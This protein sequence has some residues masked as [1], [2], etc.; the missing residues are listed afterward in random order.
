MAY[1]QTSVLLK[2][3][4]NISVAALALLLVLSA[5]SKKIITGNDTS[6]AITKD[7]S[8]H[9]TFIEWDTLTRQKIAPQ[10]NRNIGYCGY[11]R[12][13]QLQNGNLFCIYEVAGGNIECTQS[14]D[15]GKTWTTPVIIAT[16]TNGINMAVPEI[17]A[18]KDQ[19]LLASYN[20]RPATFDSSKHYGISIKKSYD[21]G[22]TWRDERL[23]YQAGAAFGDGCWEPSQ[24]QLPSGEIQLFFSNEGIYTNTNEQNISLLRAD[25]TGL[26]W[27]TE[28]QIVSFR[29]GKRD[30]MPVPILLKNKKAVI[31]SIEDNGNGQFAP[32]II[33]NTL[34]DDWATI[35]DANSAHRK[36]A[37]ATPLAS[38][39]YAGAPYLRQLNTGETILSYQSTEGRSDKWD[40]SCMNVVIGDENGNNFTNKTIPFTIPVDKIGLWNSL[41][42]LADDTVI[43]LTSTNAYSASNKVEVWMIKGHIVKR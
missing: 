19:T 29:A 33:S 40:L 43:A 16:S 14:A 9:G 18:L 2:L 27:T 15:L 39:I 37:L 7:T 5:C 30:G 24:I 26:N 38:S 8:L 32:S 13:I 41:C 4:K 20:L 36:A 23:L 12:M 42:I 3:L 21:G 10:L 34:T 6:S 17:L 31:F 11:P 25:S 1:S 28:P 22:L 35:V